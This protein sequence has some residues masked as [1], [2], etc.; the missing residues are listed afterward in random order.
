LRQLDEGW[1]GHLVAILEAGIAEKLFRSDIDAGA[2]ASALM[3]QLRGLIYQGGIG[4]KKRQVFVDQILRQTE[5]WV[6]K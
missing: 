3:V 2:T 1:H 6:R 4:G 5:H